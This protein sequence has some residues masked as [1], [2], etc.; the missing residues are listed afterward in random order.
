L[1][2]FAILPSDLAEKT[3][4][5]EKTYSIEEALSAQKALRRVAGL[6]PEQF[7]I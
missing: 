6:G 4:S 7:P 1:A 3:M 2:A 5:Q